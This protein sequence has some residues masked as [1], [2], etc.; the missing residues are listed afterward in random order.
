MKS[1][2]LDLENQEHSAVAEQDCASVITRHGLAV[3][4]DPAVV[5][6]CSLSHWQN[7]SSVGVDGPDG[8]SY[9]SHCSPFGPDS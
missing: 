8:I 7:P 1:G 3:G 4:I 9:H 5:E 2:L 6:V